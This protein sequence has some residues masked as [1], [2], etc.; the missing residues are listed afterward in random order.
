MKQVVSNMAAV[1]NLVRQCRFGDEKVAVNTE[2]AVIDG[3]VANVMLQGVLLHTQLQG[4]C[5]IKLVYV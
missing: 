3:G 2:T 5:S 1:C 4:G